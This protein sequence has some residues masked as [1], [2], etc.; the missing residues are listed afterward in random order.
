MWDGHRAG[1]N[2][3]ANQATSPLLLSLSL[4]SLPLSLP[5][6]GVCLARG[7]TASIGV[8]VTH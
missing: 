4:A 7:S 5:L 6:P 8:T 3:L 2:K 1:Q